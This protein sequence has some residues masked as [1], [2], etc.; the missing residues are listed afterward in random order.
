MEYLL[1]FFLA[2][3]IWF[4]FDS[5]G[6]IELAKAAGKRA[7]VDADVQFLDDTVASVSLKLRRHSSGH[8]ALHRTYKFEFSDTGDRRLE[9]EVILI[10]SKV[11]SVTMDPYRLLH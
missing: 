6:T 1:L 2:A 11:E 10:G 9:G 4:W 8:L 7:C 5:L 3:L